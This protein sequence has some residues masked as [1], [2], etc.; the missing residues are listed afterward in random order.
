MVARL[1]DWVHLLLISNV[2]RTGHRDLVLLY[3]T[4]VLTELSHVLNR[5]IFNRLSSLTSVAEGGEYP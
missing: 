4:H 5:H 1:F 3:I 2:G